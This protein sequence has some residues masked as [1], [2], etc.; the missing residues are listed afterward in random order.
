ISVLAHDRLELVGRRAT[1]RLAP[2]ALVVLDEVL[3]R[4][5]VVLLG[6]LRDLALDLGFVR[7]G[8]VRAGLHDRRGWRDALVAAVEPGL[9]STAAGDECKGQ[10]EVVTHGCSPFP[11]PGVFELG[12]R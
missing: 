9:R 2:T 3:E 6:V 1:R 12:G 4:G 10:D 8:R 5:L 7:R 11:C